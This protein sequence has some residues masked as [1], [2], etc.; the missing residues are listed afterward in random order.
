MNNKLF[1]AFLLSMLTLGSA[2]KKEN[3][4][5]PEQVILEY[6]VSHVSTYNGADGAIQTNLIGGEAPFSYFW[7]TGA[8]TPGISGLI[9]G[10]YTVRIVYGENSVLTET[11][12]IIQPEPQDLSLDFDITSVSRF[13]KSDGSITVDVQG[14]TAPYMAIWDERDTSLTLDNVPAGSYSV[15]VIDS[16]TPFPIT[17]SGVAEVNQPE[18][19]CGTDSIADV[20][21][22]L[23]ATVQIE[24]QCWFTQNLRTEHLPDDP[25][26]KIDGRYCSGS[27]CLNAKGAHYT[28]DA[29]MNGETTNPDD[30]YS[31]AQGICPEG[32]SIPSRQVFQDLDAILSIEGNYGDGF[33]SGAKMK[34]E[35]SSS[36]FD[37]LFAGN[38]GYG[39]YTNNNVASFWTSTEYF[40]EGQNIS[41]EGFY[42]YLTEN[43]PL[44]NSG[45]KPKTFGM[46]VR[47]MK[48][49]EE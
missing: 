33:F 32:W 8:T 44:V 28:W 13:G 3:I 40:Y 6:E 29:M 18:F 31:M 4:E 20:D 15:R 47:C 16:S 37:A 27:N 12:E 24:N 25:T 23:Y 17:T 46:S 1:F 22:N 9:A 21:G 7:S 41:N 30:P 26:T 42:F 10:E 2:C 5:S 38:W 49:L 14:G 11:I 39:V 34:G 19:I 43:I 48:L 36:G 35:D 45:H